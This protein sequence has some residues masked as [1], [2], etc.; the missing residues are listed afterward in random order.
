[1]RNDFAKGVL[2]RCETWHMTMQYVAYRSVKGALSQ[3]ERIPLTFL[4]LM[5]FSTKAIMHWFITSCEKHQ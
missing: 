2:S 3:C 1:M 4:T 5:N